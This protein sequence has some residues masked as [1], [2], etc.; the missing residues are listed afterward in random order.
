MAAGLPLL[1]GVLHLQDEAVSEVL[2][3]MEVVRKLRKRITD[4]L[5]KVKTGKKKEDRD[6]GWGLI[7]GIKQTDFIVLSALSEMD[8]ADDSM[9][10]DIEWTSAPMCTIMQRRL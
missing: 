6:A 2:E 4:R 9:D 1:Y 5:S 7:D 10:D 3:H 8:T